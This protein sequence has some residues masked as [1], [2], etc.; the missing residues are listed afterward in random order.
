M[1]TAISGGLRSLSDADIARLHSFYEKI[2]EISGNATQKALVKRFLKQLLMP[3]EGPLVTKLH[4]NYPNPFNP[5]TWIPYQL[6][7]DSDIT[8]RIYDTTGHIVRTLFSGHQG[9]GYYL[10][11]SKA[12]YWNGRNELGERVASGIYIYELS[13]PTFRR[14]RRLVILK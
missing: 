8:I 7:T 4:A 13:T 12:A 14:T 11:Q 5:E 3:I 2:E 6:A 10:S 1:S 9:S